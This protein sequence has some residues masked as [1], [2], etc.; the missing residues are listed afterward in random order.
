MCVFLYVCVR[1]KLT[2]R[3]RPQLRRSNTPSVTAETRLTASEET[4]AA[5]ALGRRNDAMFNYPGNVIVPGRLGRAHVRLAIHEALVLSKLCCRSMV[6]HFN[7]EAKCRRDCIFNY[8][9]LK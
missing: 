6:M 2:R 5:F 9:Q 1:P 8:S 3:D 4:K 7:A